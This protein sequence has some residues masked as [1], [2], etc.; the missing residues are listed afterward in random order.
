MNSINMLE[1][2]KLVLKNVY[3]DK[4]LFEKELLKSFEWLCK[5]DLVKLYRWAVRKFDEEC[6][7]IV[8]SVYSGFDF[9]DLNPSGN[10]VMN[11]HS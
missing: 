10:F 9:Q 1:L 6:C 11:A 5:A 7:N 4:I 3:K 2:Q 8:N